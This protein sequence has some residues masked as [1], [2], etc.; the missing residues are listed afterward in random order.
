MI[1]P[2]QNMIFLCFHIRSAGYDNIALPW[3]EGV[4]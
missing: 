4:W 1:Y 2:V 3:A